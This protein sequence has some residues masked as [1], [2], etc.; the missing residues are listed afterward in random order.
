VAQRSARSLALAG[1]RA[2][3]R[4]PQSADKVFNEL[5]AKASLQTVD[6]AFA[7]N[8]FY[9]VLRHLTLL[10]FWVGTL[11]TGRIEATL[12][13][14]VRLGLY[15]L[16][17]AE[18]P[19]HAAVFETVELAAPRA[20]GF[21][22]AILRTAARRRDDL[23]EAAHTQPLAVRTSHPEFLLARWQSE[24]GP[25]STLRLCAW[26]N[27]PPPIYARINRLR[28]T[29]EEFTAAYPAAM[30]VPLFPGFVE[31]PTGFPARALESG[32][33]YVQDPSTRLAVRE[34]GPQPGEKILDACAAP[35]GKS[36]LIAEAMGNDGMIVAVDCDA[37]RLNMLNENFKRLGVAIA[38]SIQHDW[39][40]SA[41]QKLRT[42][43]LFDRVLIDAP[44]TNTG[45]MRRRVDVRWRLRHDD[46]ERMHR[47]QLAIVR[48]V[49]PLLKLGG[50]LVY[51]TC[52]LEPEE[53]RDTVQTL[54]QEYGGL[55][56]VNE[57]SSVP[58]HDGFDGAYIARLLLRAS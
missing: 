48:A 57:R 33:C 55:D 52:S 44:C 14:I 50:T 36:S 49:L 31:F 9:G 4:Q 7:L 19:E 8:L 6:R 43:G 20:R 5:S 47:Q 53:N 13:D 30:P 12:R 11:R 51:S 29:P 41:P 26:N 2:W 10:D 28:M 58:F 17:I 40:R 15:Q 42:E 23:H 21:V 22:N 3:S 34:L 24:F 39:L 35:G 45:V 56:L 54:L 37:D 25:A 18:V 27:E 16:F 46:F 1:L 38:S 32:D